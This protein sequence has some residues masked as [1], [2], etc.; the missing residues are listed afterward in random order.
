MNPSSGMSFN[1][2]SLRAHRARFASR[3]N[4][5]LV[6]VGSI[7][8]LLLVLFALAMMF[9][10][11]AR[12][13]GFICLGLAVLLAVA[14]LWYNRDLKNIPPRPNP[15]SLDDFIESRLLGE[16]SKPHQIDPK[17]AWAAAV[18]CW[19]G[20]FLLNHLLFS[21][22]DI[23]SRL[24]T[25]PSA[26]PAIWQ[27]AQALMAK[28]SDTE[29]DAGCLVAAIIVNL[30]DSK[31]FL[32][33]HNLSQEELEEVYA[34]TARLNSFLNLPKPRFGGIGRDWAVGFTPTLDRFGHNISRVIEAGG[35][36]FHTLAH[37]DVLD[38]VVHMLAEGSGGVAIVGEAGSGKTGLA[39]AL[40]E[41]LLE[42]RD[43]KLRYY[44]LISLDA[45]A[46][47]SV[48]GNELERIMLTL[49]AE[50]THAQNIIIFLDEGQL[51]FGQGT[52]AFDLGKVLLPVIQNHSVKIIA[53]FT[54]GDFQKLKATNE[55]LI[56]QFGTVNI[57]EPSKETTMQ[58]LEDTALTLEA[59]NSMVISFDAVREAYRLSGQYSQDLAYPGRAITMLEQ[60]LA[61][62][63]DKLLSAESVQL[64]VEKIKG[65]KVTRA[66]A[67]ETDV[68]LHLE[69]KI[70]Q[71]MINQVPAVNVVASALRRGR[72]GVANPKRPTGSFL[73]LGPTGVG[74]TELAK[75][76]AATYFSDEQQIIRL[77][78]SE[79]QQPSDVSRLLEA[80]ANETKSLILSI[81]EQP[82]SVV[83]LDEVE[84]AHPNILNLL[85]QLLDEGQLTDESGKTAS[86]RN[87]I[88]IC[89]S[90]AG[91]ADIIAKVSAGED[92]QNFERPLVD[93][94]IASGQFKPELINRFDEVVLFRPLNRSELSQVAQLMLAEVNK[95][96]STQNVSVQLTPAALAKIVQDGY[97]PEFGARPMRRVVQKTVEN[98]VANRILAGQATAGS[99]ILLDINDL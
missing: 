43:S 50:A 97:D 13:Y 69:D 7:I 63:K 90:N 47:L 5:Q 6:R 39:Y 12:S 44:Q 41:R 10:D 98:A 51:F 30:P 70:H 38:G 36:H 54:P 87:A 1:R 26:M 75:S 92:L 79:Y 91:S 19:Q 88:I 93:K 46:I 86:F 80:G 66:Q 14:D 53:A 31:S 20:R 28:N 8:I 77:D 62:A 81:R 17:T 2:N 9:S 40:A 68:L 59:R 89:T 94:L 95:T 52:G 24:T 99:E 32:A 78:M 23:E 22:S 16:L 56:S 34:W 74:K 96:L 71:R 57:T 21:S 33:A 49:F 84:K 65:V 11:A 55:S 27:T 35:G 37:Q 58:I 29:L 73:F 83:L 48:S 76:L 15:Q 45:S 3:I 61:Y 4:E 85:L 60:S 72:A 25:E 64:S 18:S 82:F 42:G 67:A